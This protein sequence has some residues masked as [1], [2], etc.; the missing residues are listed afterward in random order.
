[1]AKT[2][3]KAFYDSAVWQ[4]Q[5]D[6]V[7]KRDGYLCVR[8]GRPASDVHHKIYLTPENI[9]RYDIA[10]DEK[11]LISLCKDCHNREHHSQDVLPKYV[12]DES[13]Q[14]VPAP[15]FRQKK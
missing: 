11:N 5:R 7:L 9:H 15:H 1:M 6:Y 12:F 10:L 4:S 13:G 8:C 2:F 3:S 14:V